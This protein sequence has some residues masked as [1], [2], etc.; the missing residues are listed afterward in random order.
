MLD[1]DVLRQIPLVGEA[2]Q[3]PSFAF[4]KRP[5][6]F[7][8]LEF[9]G[10]RVVALSLTQELYAR[11]PKASEGELSKRLSFL[12]SK[13]TMAQIAYS[14]GL[15]GQLELAPKTE[16][17]ESIFADALE[18]V[19][20]A[21]YLH[22]GFFSVRSLV[23]QLWAP[24]IEHEGWIDGKSALQE[25]CHK[26]GFPL[27]EYRLLNVQGPEHAPSFVIE[28]T[29][30]GKLFQGVG[31]TKKAAENAAALEALNALDKKS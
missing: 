6:P 31:L 30:Q 12:A 29:I 5:S 4:R 2:L 1:W 10:D 8:R 17:A 14:I 21:L 15:K 16:M 28:I 24:Y 19:L 13:G 18:A 11:F 25:W 27:P 20:G 22:R 26:K 23:L 3:H 9:L 7:E